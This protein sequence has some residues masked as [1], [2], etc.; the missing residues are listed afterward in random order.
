MFSGKR[1]K[2]TI[3][4]NW[5]TRCNIINCLSG[6]K[7]SEDKRYFESDD[8]VKLYISARP[9]LPTAVIT[10]VKKY[11]MEKRSCLGDPTFVVDVACGSGQSSVPLTAEFDSVLGTDIS[12]G[13]IEQ[14]NL[15]SHPSNIRFQVGSAEI[16]PV[17]DGS[18]DAV[19]CC[20]ALHWLNHD[21]FFA[22]VQRVLKKNGVL[23]IVG[24]KDAGAEAPLG[25]SQEIR[26]KF[27]A[28][29]EQFLQDIYPFFD[30]AV[31]LCLKEYKDI[32]PLPGFADTA[33]I[34]TGLTGERKMPAQ[35]QFE[36][37]LTTSAYQIFKNK[38]EANA[39]RV[40]EALKSRF[41][42][43]FPS[44]ETEAVFQHSTVL[45]LGRKS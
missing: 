27:M 40:S 26:D 38:D 21:K 14:A 10:T 2:P 12:P 42:E 32:H 3:I 1:K 8:H 15:S 20:M 19:F 22:E 31:E 6:L 34:T 39:L 17:E 13:Q 30:P 44:L 7:M 9:T 18:V 16:I 23:A 24:Y 45:V 11:L 41:L 29:Q 4:F 35:I 28:A 37:M 5:C 43:C 33:Y 36:N 25:V